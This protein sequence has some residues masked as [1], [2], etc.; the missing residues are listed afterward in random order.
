MRKTLRIAQVQPVRMPLAATALSAS[1]MK[2]LVSMSVTSNLLQDFGYAFL[3]I[4]RSQVAS[5]R[6]ITS[7]GVHFASEMV[8]TCFPE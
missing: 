4:R 8:E 2:A 7:S 3:L 5:L 6:E 1:V